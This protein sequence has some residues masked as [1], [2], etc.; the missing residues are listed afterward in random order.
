MTILSHSPPPKDIPDRVSLDTDSPH[1]FP[2][3]RKVG[4]KIDGQVIFNCAEF[5]VSERWVKLLLPGNRGVGFRKERGKFI[6]VLKRD[7]TVETYWR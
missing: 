7:V 5:C 1:Y 6:T 3:C 4:V 2:W